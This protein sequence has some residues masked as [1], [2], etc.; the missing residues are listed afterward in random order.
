M[1]A[2]EN[3]NA[4]VRPTS[5]VDDKPL[6]SHVTVLS[7]AAGGGGNRTWTCNYCSKKVVGSYSKVKAHLLKLP[8]H[9]VA[10]CKSVSRDMLQQIKEEHDEVERKKSQEAYQDKQKA[11]YLSLPDGS[12]LQQHKKR[13][14]KEV[15]PLEK[16]FNISQR[17]KTDKQCARMFFASGLPFNFAK[18]PF[19]IDYSRT[20]A[21]SSL[22][23]YTPPTYNRIRTTL[24]GQE[25]EHVYRKLHPIRDSWMKKGVSI[26]SDG[27]SDRQRRP[28]INLMAASA[29]G[30]MFL[31]SVDASGIIKDGEYVSNVFEEALHGFF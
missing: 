28:L 24:L 20:L 18:S 17:E 5:G 25:K 15:G 23:G 7:V 9:G 10:P 2:E 14:G 22:S 8:N 21:N 30:A 31:K 29:G 12:D 11:D 3:R 13:K 26:V 1:A 6:W 19:F 27:W 16:S 4:A